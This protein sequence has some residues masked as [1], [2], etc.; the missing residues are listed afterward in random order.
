MTVGQFIFTNFRNATATYRMTVRNGE[1]IDYWRYVKQDIFQSEINNLETLSLKEEEAKYLR[2]LNLFTDDYIEFLMNAP[3]KNVRREVKW[4]FQEKNERFVPAVDGLWHVVMLYE[5]FFLSISNELYAKHYILLNRIEDTLVESTAFTRLQDKIKK[6]SLYNE[7]RKNKIKIVEF[8][9]RRR[10]SKLWQENVISSLKFNN[11]ISGT[12]NVMFA[13]K[14]GIKAVGSFGHEIVMGMQAIF[15][16][17]ESQSQTF[18]LWYEFYGERSAIAL[19]DTLGTNKFFKDFT[20]DLA[21]KYNGLRHDSG[22]PFIWGDQMISMYQSF[23]IDPKTKTLMF[24]DGLSVDAII[25]LNDYFDGKVQLSY[26]VGTNLTNDSCLP[27]PQVVMKI[28]T[29][30]KKNVAKLSNNPAKASCD[31]LSYI[32]Y[33]KSICG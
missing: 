32:E 2:S 5:I 4:E 21:E 19:N 25:K 27:I 9:T 7:G 17:E 14:T 16:A 15:G 20:K 10:M 29:C 6:L 1:K 23:D 26:G 3:L 31:D 18:K 13:Q 30:N 33:L 8:G 28:I 24:S 12:S 11:L 22:D